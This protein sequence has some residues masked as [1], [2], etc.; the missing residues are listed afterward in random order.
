MNMKVAIITYSWS[1]NWG[2][3]LQA[4]ALVEYLNSVGHE[5]KLI[6]YRPFDNKLISTVKSIPDGLVDLLTIPA[7]MR[8]IARYNEFR[9]NALKLTKQC[10]T[11]E[12]LTTLNGEFDAF[13]TGS[14]QIWNIGLGV[15][16][17]FYLEFAELTKR[18]ISYA[19]SFGVTSIPEQHKKDTI[20]GLHNIQNISVRE[21]SGAKIVKALDGRTATMVLDPVFLLS[22]EKWLQ[23]AHK[24]KIPK[25]AYIFVYP[26]QVTEKLRQV[27]KELKNKTGFEAISP[28]Y[29]PGC[30]TVK[31]IGPREFI[32]YIANAEYVVASSFHA[33]AFSL[34]FQKKLFVIG[35]SQTGSRTTDLLRLVRLDECC[36]TDTNDIQDIRWDYNQASVIRDEKIV[37]SK[38]FLA[39]ALA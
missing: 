9:Q 20:D 30:K 26:T 36:V 7:S 13:I 16:K 31:D 34:I 18:R 29:V 8:R 27:V 37:Q 3:I 5:A 39:E 12:E 2:T 28:F 19:A 11:T 33:T 10:N 32:N 24:P 14:D 6:N 21:E 38:R 23:V 4:Y 35:H 22:K 1:Q 25:A 17:D 15:C